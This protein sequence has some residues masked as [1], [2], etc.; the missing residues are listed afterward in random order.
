MGRNE[1]R[2][3]LTERLMPLTDQPVIYTHY[4]PDWD[5]AK[6]SPGDP[7]FEACVCRTDSRLISESD[8]VDLIADLLLADGSL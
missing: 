8:D 4:C 5:F 3:H 2:T 1:P 6:I 7:E